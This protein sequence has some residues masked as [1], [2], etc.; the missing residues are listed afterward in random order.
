ML[1]LRSSFGSLDIFVV[2][3]P[4]GAEVKEEDYFG[5]DP[6]CRHTI[7]TF[8]ALRA[9]L[10]NLVAAKIAPRNDALSIIGGDFNYVAD[11]KERISLDTASPSKRN[12]AGKKPISRRPSRDL[13]EYMSFSRVNIR[14]FRAVQVPN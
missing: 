8:P 12:D 5:I 3:F 10:R 11:P 7:N 4:T 13:M 1:R 6:D 14:M 9:H 2:Y